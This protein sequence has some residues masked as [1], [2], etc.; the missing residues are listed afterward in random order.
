MDMTP[1]MQPDPATSTAASAR[2]L[3]LA[4]ILPTLNERD[5]LAPLV[6]RIEGALGASGWE[7]LVVDDNSADGTSDEARRLSLSDPR[8]RVLQ[9]IGRRSYCHQACASSKS[10][11]RRQ[12]PS[13]CRI[14]RTSTNYNSVTTIIFVH[15][16]LREWH[17]I[18]PQIWT[19]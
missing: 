6:E 19:V 16:A 14:F 9:R 7:V 10:R 4:I 3:E 5:N 8:V 2:P 15:L 13:P 1:Q 18:Q 17:P 11:F 12:Q